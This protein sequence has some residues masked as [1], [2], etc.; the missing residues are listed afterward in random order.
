[1]NEDYLFVYGTLQRGLPGSRHEL[2]EGSV[3]FLGRGEIAGRLIDLGSYPGLVKAVSAGQRVHGE[4]YRVRDTHALFA[5]LDRYEGCSPACP[6]PHEYRRVLRPVVLEDGQALA[7]WVYE[8]IG[9]VTG[10]RWI[11]GGKYRP[12]R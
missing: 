10:G 5:R 4:I 8:Y 7:A 12:R 11:P 9:P 1:M 6:R 3:E 2:L